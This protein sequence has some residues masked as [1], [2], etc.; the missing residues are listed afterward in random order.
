MRNKAIIGD[1]MAENSTFIRVKNDD[2]N[3]HSINTIG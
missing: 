2:V 1:D 3:M